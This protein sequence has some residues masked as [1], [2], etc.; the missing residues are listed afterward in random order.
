MVRPVPGIAHHSTVR[1]FKRGRFSNTL[2]NLEEELERELEVARPACIEDRIKTAAAA[3]C[4]TEAAIRH[5][6]GGAECGTVQD[7]TRRTEVRV[8]EHVEHV[9]LEPEADAFLDWKV[10]MQGEIQLP[11][12]ESA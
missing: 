2:W 3:V 5:L 12:R 9:N 10:P 1:V 8:I 7:C 11:K 4:C 6:G